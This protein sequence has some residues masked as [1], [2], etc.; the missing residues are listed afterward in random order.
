MIGIPLALAVLSSWTHPD[1]T[2]N[3]ENTKWL[4]Y[5]PSEI[6]HLLSWVSSV[7]HKI[8]R[9]L[10][11]N[12]KCEQTRT[13]KEQHDADRALDGSSQGFEADGHQI[14]NLIIRDASERGQCSLCQIS[15]YIEKAT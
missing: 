15:T 8:A 6:S 12:G 9:L 14:I 11:K 3:N 5:V 1:T 10:K 13:V 4:L 7:W 2:I